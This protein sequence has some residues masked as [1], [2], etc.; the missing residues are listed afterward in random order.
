MNELSLK[1]CVIE[2]KKG[3]M[4]VFDS[5]Y[6]AT[7]HQVFY[8]IVA[9][10]KSYDLAEDLLQDTFVS[11]LKNI[12]RVDE[13]SSILGFLMVM[14]KNITLDYFKKAN[15]T[16]EIDEIN[17]DLSSYDKSYIDQDL[18]LKRIEKILKEKEFQIFTMHVLSELSFDE[19]SKVLNKPL[20][21]VLWSYNNS[22][23]KLRKELEV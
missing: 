2:L 3:N 23:K 14:S 19:I 7:K 6:E 10:T 8:N 11:F 9:I 1:D 15:R 4:E 13:N 18:L 22:I 17:D 20:G 12:N 21:T 16:R 5:F